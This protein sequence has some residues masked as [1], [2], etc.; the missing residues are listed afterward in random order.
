MLKEP[1]FAINGHI[2][3]IRREG[4]NMKVIFWWE[5]LECSRVAIEHDLYKS[6]GDVNMC[7]KFDMFKVQVFIIF[8]GM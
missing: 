3:Q 7:R 8:S 6:L 4:N 1:S 5:G 2:P